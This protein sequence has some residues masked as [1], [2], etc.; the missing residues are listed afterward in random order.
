MNVSRKERK[1]REEGYELRARTGAA[2]VRQTIHDAL[3][4]ILEMQFTK[5]NQQ[6]KFLVGQTQLREHLLRVH[7]RE[8]FNGLQFHDD[9]S[10]DYDV[11]PKSFFEDQLV[12]ADRY[13]HLP[14]NRQA[15]LSQFMGE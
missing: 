9:Y 3:N 5:V 11:G 10:V 1:G 6:A 8:T 2:L 4:A 7:T 13:W 12:I 15:N 14:F